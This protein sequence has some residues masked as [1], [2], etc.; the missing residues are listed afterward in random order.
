MSGEA[1][2]AQV[3][4]VPDPDL[5][6]WAAATAGVHEVV[7]PAQDA[8][9]AAEAA[10]RLWSEFGFHHAPTPVLEM[11]VQA[12]EAGYATALRDIRDGRLDG[13]IRMWRP[14]L[15]R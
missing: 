9:A 8:C 12:I 15:M 13:E 10:A 2:T 4:P 11:L 6:S 3:N 14:D 1:D 5:S 7:V